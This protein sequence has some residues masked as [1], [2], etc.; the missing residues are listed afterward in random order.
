MFFCRGLWLWMCG[1]GFS[2]AVVA[3]S[4]PLRIAAA[5]DLKF[6]FGE[7]QQQFK[8]NYPDS[9][10]SIS[11][12]SSGKFKTQIE[13]GAPF[14][15][16]YSA[17]IRY[18]QLLAQNGLV[19]GEAIP[20]AIGYIVIWQSAKAPAVSD[21]SDLMNPRYQK[22]AIANPA[23]APYGLRAKEALESMHL[24]ADIQPKLVYG[25]NIAMTAHYVQSGAADIGI[26][27]LSLARSPVMLSTGHYTKIDP[28]MHSPLIQGYALIKQETLHP[29]AKV[30]AD[31]VFSDE[32]QQI[33]AGYG[34]E[35]PPA[36]VPTFVAQP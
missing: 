3:D 23:H 36:N 6:A 27:A 31:Y 1:L 35:P 33:M 19:V 9:P 7:V 25:E 17:D 5:S 32:A 14:D 12:G 20:Y 18:P 4:A 13:N 2:V 30:F 10:L 21:F 22:L 15:L 26:I 16:F 24:W 34:F 11:Y 8:V 29:M 28:V